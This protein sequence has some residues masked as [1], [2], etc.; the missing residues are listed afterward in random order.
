M[1]IFSIVVP[2]RVE[3]D[4][5]MQKGVKVKAGA[6]V[7]LQAEVY[8]KPMP[9][10][11]WRRGDD[12]LKSGDGQVISHQRHHFQLEMSSV[13]KEHTGTYA[14]VAEN[15]SGTKTAEI[16]VVVLGK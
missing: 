9:K 8:G 11:N 14:I 12:N 5:R 2:P 1:L 7:L 4:A 6:T 16:Q 13:T 3:L 10:V 15:A